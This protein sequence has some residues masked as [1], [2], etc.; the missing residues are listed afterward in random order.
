MVPAIQSLFLQKFNPK[1]ITPLGPPRPSLF[2][3][4]FVS[5]FPPTRIYDV[6]A[7]QK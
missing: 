7:V 4:P 5:Q 1:V 6:P 2:P 3:P